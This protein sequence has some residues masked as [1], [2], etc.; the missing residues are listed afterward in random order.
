MTTQADPGG[1]APKR[2]TKLFVMQKQ[3]LVQIGQL[4]RL[5]KC[6]KAFGF[7]PDLLT[8]TPLG[9]L[10]QTHVTGA[11]SA[12]SMWPP[13]FDPGSASV[14]KIFWNKNNKMIK[15]I[16]HNGN[17]FATYAYFQKQLSSWTFVLHFSRLLCL[18][19]TANCL[20][21]SCPCRQCELN[22]RQV[23]T[24]E[25]IK[26]QNWTGLV[27]CSFDFFSN[28]RSEHIFSI[29]ILSKYFFLF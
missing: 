14:T 4:L 11:C 10:P 3:I 15:I 13:D 16:S 27:F 17:S 9:A 8:S 26:F 24:V 12:L 25:D 22:W 18:F 23:K 7:A 20:V 1:H 6:K 5:S 19:N 2:P 21:L 28:H 29:F